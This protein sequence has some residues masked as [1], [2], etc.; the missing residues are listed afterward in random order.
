MPT[1]CS[2]LKEVVQWAELKAVVLELYLLHQLDPL[3]LLLLSQALPPFSLLEPLAERVVVVKLYLVRWEL[4]FV[5]SVSMT[6][7]SLKSSSIPCC[8]RPT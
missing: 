7:V 5:K 6:E 3:S 8:I 1:W 2:Y 4:K